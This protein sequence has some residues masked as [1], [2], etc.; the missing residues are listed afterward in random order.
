MF[1]KAARMRRLPCFAFLIGSLIAGALMY[2]PS[3]ARAE[4]GEISIAHQ[5][6]V[7]YLPLIV[8]RNGKLIEQHAEKAGI[9]PLKV[10]W[11]VFGSGADMN[12]ALISRTLDFASGGIAPVL[13]IWDRTK[14][15]LAVKGVG[16]LG[17]FPLYLTTIN[18]KIRTIKDFA[19]TDR[20]ALPAVKVSI[21]AM[22][23]QMAASQTFGESKHDAL[24]ALTVSVNHPQAVAA[25]LSGTEI[26]AHFGVAPFQEQ[27]L[28]DARVHRVLSSYDVLGGP[29]TVNSLYTTARFRAENPKVFD[30]VMGA[31][32]EAVA[33]I[34]RDKVWAANVYSE[35]EKSKVDPAFM[36]SII[37]SPEVDITVSPQGFMKFAE[38]M[39]KTKMIK[40]MPS[41]WKDVFFPEVHGEAGS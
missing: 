28:K 35:E 17:S 12:V 2:G 19:S 6:G 41:S 5:F 36:H 25:M 3:A 11:S 7:A 29:A 26:T 20:I 31:L 22:L 30:A 8:M 9:G 38:F 15:S 33:L 24:D 21:Q 10:T 27:E 16:A 14:G 4:V 37:S 34:N 18:P 40:E 1:S 23:L 39:F 13:Q 32:R